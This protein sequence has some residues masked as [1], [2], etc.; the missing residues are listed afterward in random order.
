MNNEEKNSYVRERITEA[1]LKLLAEKKLDDISISE[2]TQAAEV[3]RVSFYRNYSSKEDILKQES[4]RLLKI[5]GKRF[6]SDPESALGNLFPSL[7]DFFLAH[8]QFYVTLA[9]AGLSDVIR[10]TILSTADISSDM[11]NIEAYVKSFWTYGIY[12]WTIEWINRGM[13]ESGPEMHKL[14]EQMQQK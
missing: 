1:L 11:P 4:D 12:G 8:K 2:I 6:E 13:K 9:K 3:G 14:F 10:D 7:F 5:W